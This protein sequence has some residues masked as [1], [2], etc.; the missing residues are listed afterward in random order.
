MTDP[1][2]RSGSG[3]EFKAAVHLGVFGLAIA[4]LGY[5]ALAYSQRKE[6]HLLSNV[7]AYTGLA[8]FEVYQ[9]DRHWKADR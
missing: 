9:M 3:E 8:A 2:L 5:N 1:L 7:V 4:C 6:R